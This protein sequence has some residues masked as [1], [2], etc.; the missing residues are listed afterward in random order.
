MKCTAQ[1]VID[2]AIAEIGYLEKKTNS[3]LDDK[4]VNAG[5]GNYTKYARDLAL[6]GYYQGNK[7]G[8]AWC[9]VFVS[10]LF[11][12]AFGKEVGHKLLCEDIGPYGAG[13]PY[14]ARYFRQRGQ[15]F[16]KGPRP[17][18]QIFF[19]TPGSESHTGIVEKVEGAY[20]Y[21][22]EGNT[23]GASG[24]IANG[25]G[26]CRKKYV[27]GSV[28][29]AGYGRPKYDDF[30]DP[31][32]GGSNPAVDTAPAPAEKVSVLEWQRAAIADGF[33]FPRYGADGLWG[34]E[35]AGVAKNALVMR[36]KN[37]QYQNLT[38]IVQ[39]VVGVE[40]DGLC[41]PDTDKAIKAYQKQHGLTVDGCVGINTWRKILGI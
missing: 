5:S 10:W 18:D 8:Y 16:T 28:L 31:F 35:C 40:I 21:T 19:G 38:R 11:Y 6:A 29:I 14:S 23:S 12:K 37:Y 30:D 33:A 20:V 13:C 39:R 15:F 3:Q 1:K 27:N 9:D 2:L 4:T 32:P 22:I 26:V 7:N 36:R 25:G 41:G 17:G 24:V 34:S